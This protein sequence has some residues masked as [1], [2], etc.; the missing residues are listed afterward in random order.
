[1]SPPNVAQGHPY[2]AVFLAVIGLVLEQKATQSLLLNS[3]VQQGDLCPAC[4]WV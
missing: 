2:L 1:M 3:A 4:V